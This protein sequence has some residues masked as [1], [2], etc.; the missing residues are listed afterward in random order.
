MREFK[1]EHMG[2]QCTWRHIAKTEELLANMAAVHLR[3]VHS[4]KEV[5]PDML[6]KI[7]N[8]FT[9]PSESDVAR[10]EI[11][12]LKEYTCDMGAGCSWRYIAM[13]EELIVDGAAIHAREVH[14][15]KTFTP[16]MVARVK[17]SAHEWKTETDQQMHQVNSDRGQKENRRRRRSDRRQ[18][19]DSRYLSL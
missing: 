18:R 11:A 19:S 7:K 16:E 3:D 15:I 10:M 1:C 2:Y 13:T 5:S 17:N 8:L 6:G 4:I 9:K 14:G 12:V